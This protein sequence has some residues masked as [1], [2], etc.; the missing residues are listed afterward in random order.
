MSEINHECGV[1]AIYHLSGR[2]RSPVCP[3]QG[4]RQIS[5][6]LPRMLLDI[7]NRGQLAAGM[8]TYNPD[9]PRLLMTRKDVGTVTEV[10]RLNHRAKCESIMQGLAGSASIGHVR[11]ATCGQ[12]DRNY[13]QPFEREHIHKRKWFSF[14]F[15]GQ[16]ANYSLLKERLLADGDHHLVLDTDTEILM[17]EIGRVLSQSTERVEWIDVLRQVAGDFDG[18]YSLAL[19]SAEGEMIVARDPLGIKPMCYV[20][21]GPFFAAAS[22]SV[23]LLNLGFETSQ[24]KS[25]AP[26][27]AVIVH[28][29][30]GVRIEQFVESKKNAHCFFEWIYFANVAS[31]LDDRSV[32]LTRTRLGEELAR[33]E[34]EDG[35]IPLDDPDTIIVPVPDTSK[36]AA[37]AMAYQLSIPCREGLIRNRYAGRTFIEGGR[38][39][40]AKA[41]TKY[42]PLRD[43]LEGKRVILVEDSIVRSTTM[44]VLLDRIREVGG[45]KEIHVRVACPPIVAP[46]FYGI[47]MSTI[48]Q[49][50]AP[51]YFGTEGLLTPEAQQRLADDLGADSL[52]YL[53]VEA[54]ARAIDLP[55][56]ELCQACV[57]GQYPTECG[58]HLYQIALDNRGSDVDSGR[59]YEQLAAVMNSQ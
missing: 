22:E 3:E 2:G 25:L 33:S 37:D 1:A 17:H 48:D 4:P 23:A 49:L 52:R 27:H 50:I 20:H 18:A 57:T 34:R 19:L 59:T 32:Y 38:A 46:C 31:T 54:I 55:E 58:Q 35:R 13:A 53:P 6:L 39:R 28:P 8:T 43:V 12:D 7:Q 10:F 56:T 36:A 15:N 40:K 14:C 29:E 26:G 45:A 51:K 30:T 21:E 9:Q 24:I 11:Y 41:A 42:T 47:D 16:L 5:R 44:N